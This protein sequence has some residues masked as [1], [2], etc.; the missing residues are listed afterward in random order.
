MATIPFVKDPSSPKIYDSRTGEWIQNEQEFFNRAAQAGLPSNKFQQGVNFKVGTADEITKFGQAKPVSA[1]SPVQATQP[2][3]TPIAGQLVE[4]YYNPPAGTPNPGGWQ[5]GRKMT[6]PVGG[7]LYN[8]LISQGFSPKPQVS[9][10]SAPIQPTQT[11]VNAPAPLPAPQTPQTA[12]TTIPFIKDPNSS[13]I[14]DSR[15]GE[16]IQNEQEFFKRAKE[17]GLPSTKFQQGVNFRVGNTEQIKGYEGLVGQITESPEEIA[18]RL[19]PDDKD[20]Q[21][22]YSKSAPD[23]QKYLLLFEQMQKTTD[24]ATQK[25]FNDA[26][27]KAKLQA[28]P[29][30]KELLR[31]SKDEVSRF[32]LQTTEDYTT[33][34][35]EIDKRISEIKSDLLLS[36]NRLNED[37][38]TALEDQLRQYQLTQESLEKSVSA[39][40]LTF[41][42]ERQ[43]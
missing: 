40:G 32:V 29:I 20:L 37:E 26:L 6:A 9:P 16:W 38:K 15:T 7:N 19:F 35:N 14:Y 11:P 30:S 28:D 24:K 36:E 42:S 2:T 25:I 21:D 1:P 18:I 34:K 41:S 39:A 31:I 33:R 3:E 5:T 27:E 8:D 43:K 23:F 22:I 12:Q 4:I 10:Q 17:A 13:K